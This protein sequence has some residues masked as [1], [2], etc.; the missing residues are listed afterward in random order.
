MKT[1]THLKEKTVLLDAELDMMD[2]LKA[3]IIDKKTY[4]SWLKGLNQTIEE[5]A[6][7]EI[8]VFEDS[9]EDGKLTYSQY[10]DKKRTINFR[11]KYQ[12]KFHKMFRDRYLNGETNKESFSENY[13]MHFYMKRDAIKEMIEYCK[14]N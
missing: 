4:S 10:V 14:N 12:K 11:L 13:L 9:L 7:V 5:Q 1:I 3:G 8:D 6:L 2:K